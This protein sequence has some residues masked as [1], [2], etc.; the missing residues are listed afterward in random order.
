MT[1]IL[2]ILAIAV[3]LGLAFACGYLVAQARSA[4][5]LLEAK[6]ILDRAIEH[7]GALA[8]EGKAEA[9]ARKEELASGDHLAELL[10]HGPPGAPP[11][12][13]R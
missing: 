9:R 7:T 5:A 8:A 12:S 4:E 3:G 11:G 2:S 13:S 6:T 10:E 1:I